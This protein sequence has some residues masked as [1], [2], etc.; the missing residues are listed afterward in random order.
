MMTALALRHGLDRLAALGYGAAYDAV[1]SGFGPYERLLDEVADLV[2]RSCPGRDPADIQ[3]LD[4]ACGTGTAAARLARAAGRVVGVDPVERLV[5]VAR[6]RR[7]LS[8]LSF[9]RVDLATDALPGAGTFDALV[10]L[11]TLYWHPDPTAFL[12]ACR[13][14]LRP[15]GH[16][17]FLTYSRPA[18][19]GPTFRRLWANDGPAAAVRSLRWLVPT[20]MFEALRHHRPRYQDREAFHRTLTDAGFEI[21]EARQTFLSGISLL[22]WTRIP[23]AG[24]AARPKEIS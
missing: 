21:L 15:G 7:H 16:G 6:R 18:H 19:V 17:I 3:V 4:V 20:A 9:H 22:A 8:R 5:T 1:V 13:R 12:A 24:D 23:P 11:H 2:A 14:A 10:S